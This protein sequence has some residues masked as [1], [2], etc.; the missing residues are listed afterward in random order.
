MSG[1]ILLVLRILLA[2]ALFAF[3]AFALNTLWQDLKRQSNLLNQKQP[4]PITL[5]YN[6]AG[7]SQSY[8]FTIS[9][10]L[11]GRDPA[12][13][14]V[15]NDST[16]SAQHARLIHRQGQW[17]IEDLRSTNGTFLNQEPVFTPLVVTSGDELQCGQARLTI[18]VSEA[19]GKNILQPPKTSDLE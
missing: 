1:I 12:C 6:Q 15:I 19:A 11:V 16:V 18:S 4:P 3:L 5:F 2:T 10:V 9:A 13:D 8:R 17:W 14:C 7:E